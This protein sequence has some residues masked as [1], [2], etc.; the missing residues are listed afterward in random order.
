P[1]PAQETERQIEKR[2]QAINAPAYSFGQPSRRS[3]QLRRKPLVQYLGRQFPREQNPVSGNER[4]RFS[5]PA[6]H[7]NKAGAHNAVAVQKNAV[8][9]SRGKDCTIADFRRAEATISVP[10]MLEA[11]P[12]FALPIID[13]LCRA[14]TR[15]IVGHD[16]LKIGVTL[17]CK[18]PQDRI[19]R[20]FAVVRRDD[21]GDQLGHGC[22][23]LPAFNRCCPRRQTP[24]ARAS[25]NVNLPPARSLNRHFPSCKRYRPIFSPIT[26]RKRSK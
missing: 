1:N 23:L 13:Q 12:G 8:Y 26:K 22:P 14:G 16:D 5:E 3:P 11:A 6:M 19:K 24:R 15:T 17:P 10:G 25:R 21:D 20:I 2:R 7:C 4:A 9:T 18:R